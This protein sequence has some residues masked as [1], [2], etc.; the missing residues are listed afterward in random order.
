MFDSRRRQ[1]FVEP[2]IQGGIV[3]RA[4]VYWLI[5][6]ATFIIVDMVWTHRIPTQAGWTALAVECVPLVIVSMA[7]LP[8]IIFDA[9][10]FSARFAGPLVRFRQALRQAAQG[11]RVHPLR[12]RRG[13]F[14]HEL[15]DE[16]NSYLEANAPRR[17]IEQDD[18]ERALRI[19]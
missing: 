2:K 3:L 11:E 16:L 13:D 15:A 6:M 14:L 4:A 12:F 8:L 19:G 17:P 7:I 10:T 9:T 18:G 1:F 5:A